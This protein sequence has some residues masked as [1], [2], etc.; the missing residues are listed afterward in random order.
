MGMAISVGMGAVIPR[1]S[2]WWTRLPTLQTVS[3][4]ISGIQGK[5]TPSDE[6]RIRTE[7]AAAVQKAGG[8]IQ[9]VQQVQSDITG[10]LESSGGSSLPQYGG[11]IWPEPFGVDLKW[12]LLGGL[13]LV[14]GIFIL[15]E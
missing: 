11:S 13:G 10:A 14:V 5:I 7:A 12:W 2:P 1:P 8:T 4:V 15:K 9:D 3:H 6:Q